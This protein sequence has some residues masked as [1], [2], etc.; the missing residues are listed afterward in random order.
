MHRPGVRSR[1]AHGVFGLNPPGQPAPPRT[2][3]EWFNAGD[4]VNLANLR[5]SVVV[6]HAFQMLCPPIVAVT[7]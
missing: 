1:A 7:S 4:T 5:G 3:C 6:L 2:T